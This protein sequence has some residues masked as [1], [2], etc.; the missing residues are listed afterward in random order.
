ML[1]LLDYL[2][3]N[4]FKIYIVSGG[5]QEFMQAWAPEIYGIPTENIIGTTFK[6]EAVASGDSINTNNSVPHKHTTSSENHTCIITDN[7]MGK[8]ALDSSFLA[9]IKVIETDPKQAISTEGMVLIKGG[10]FAMGGDQAEGFENMPK[11][12][13]AQGDEFP[14]HK[15]Q[16]SDFYM[17]EHEVTVGEY[18]TF[19]MAT[20]YKT[21]AE[22]DINWEE[23]KK[24]LPPGTPKPDENMLKAG[25]MVFHYVPDSVDKESLSNWWTYTAGV[26]WKN[27]DGTQPQIDDILR[28]PVTQV[29][30]YDAL[31]Y[32]KWV[33]KRLPTEAEFEYAMRAGKNNT[34]YPWG[35]EKISHDKQYGNFL[36]GNFPYNNTAE[37]GFMGIAPVKQ[38]PPNAYGLYDIAGNVWEWTS[39]WYSPLYYKN[40][41]EKDTVT[42]N[43]QGPQKSMEIYD[44]Y[45]INKVVKGGS[46][47]CNDSWCSGYRNSRRMR[48]SPDSGMQH[49]GFRLVRDVE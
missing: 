32:A 5:S 26:N 7:L 14:K 16:V 21:V 34:M 4:D 43:P 27:P 19:V 38:F 48:L 18:R 30:W 20:G 15:V 2:R 31:A 44:Q 37:D 49:L 33:G 25:A 8:A 35:N 24:Q 28:Q 39:D 6:R 41:S 42:I 9:K 29:S 40:L 13:L 45:A 1:E 36:Q 22:Q 10:T 12:A 47:L 23:L 46:F 17:D 3:K 11:T